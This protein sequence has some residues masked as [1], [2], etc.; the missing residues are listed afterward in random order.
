MKKIILFFLILFTSELFSQTWEFMNKDD[1][2]PIAPYTGKHEF[3]SSNCLTINKDNIAI[4]RSNYENWLI[5]YNK[6]TKEWKFISKE[7]VCDMIKEDNNYSEYDFNYGMFFLAYDNKGKLWTKANQ[8]IIISILN[9]TAKVYTQ[10]FNTDENK[11][12]D[13]NSIA[14]LKTD[15]N[16]DVWAIITQFATNKYIYSLCKFK[17]T[18]FVTVNN[19]YTSDVGTSVQKSIAFDNLGRVWQS[20]ADSIY[21]I[22][23]EKVIK[24]YCTL[25]FPNGYGNISQIVINS[26]NVAYILN[27]SLMLYKLDGE[28]YSSFNYMLEIERYE[29]PHISNNY[30]MCIDSSDNVWVTG[31]TCNLYKLDS[32]DNWTKYI[33][34]NP[35]LE[36]FD[37]Y[38][39][40]I[41]ADNEG[42]IWI[43]SDKSGNLSWGIYVF[44]PDSTTSVSENYT[45]ESAALP[46]VWIRKLYP[47]PSNSNVTVGFFPE[48]SVSSKCKIQMYNTL[49]MLVKDIHYNLEYDSYNM[50]ASLNFSVSDL[51]R[52]AYIL[53]ISA[54]KS[55]MSRLLLVG[56]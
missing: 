30:M 56:F 32:A 7:D 47:N 48:R 21:V 11:F 43:I 20:N 18:A 19:L 46:D 4:S 37:C 6:S 39:N 23:N 15:K 14:D 52:G 50:S 33:V 27:Y 49:G 22:E 41:E 13:I 24:K 54:G 3:L 38:K 26:K 9:D 16:G 35:G 36:N 40:N 53:T 1:F 42:K 10:V 55:N 51:P 5:I 44:N 12:I 25:D 17:D 29:N 28:K 31:P 8:N 2:L 34:P 45:I